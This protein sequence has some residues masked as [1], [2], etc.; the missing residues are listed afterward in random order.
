MTATVV[1]PRRPADHLEHD[2]AGRRAR[3]TPLNNDRGRRRHADR[4]R[5][6]RHLRPAGRPGHLHRRPGPGLLPRHDA[7]QR[8]RRASSRSRSVVPLNPGPFGAT[9]FQ[10]NFAPRSGVGTYS[11]S[12]SPDITRPD[13]HRQRLGRHPGRRAGQLHLDRR[14]P[15]AT[16]PT[17][18]ARLVDHRAGQRLPGQ[19]GRR[20]PDGQ[21]EH[22][23]TRSTPT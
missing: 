16:A 21:P 1:D 20:Q 12:I 13:P 14:A 17:Y 7:E 10:V 5:L 22:Q 4:Q 6:R 23:P 2:G 3:A 11:Y 19:P 15:D 18:D 8:H 9:Q